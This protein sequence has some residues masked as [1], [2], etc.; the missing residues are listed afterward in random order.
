LMQPQKN[1]L[2]RITLGN[3]SSLLVFNL[4]FLDFT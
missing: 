1:F 3:A 2:T 4:H